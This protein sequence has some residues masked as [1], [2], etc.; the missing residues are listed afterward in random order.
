MRGCLIGEE[1]AADLQIFLPQMVSLRGVVGTSLCRERVLRLSLHRCQCAI[2]L[3]I[4]HVR[5]NGTT[6]SSARQSG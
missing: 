1:V 4:V 6:L 2:G 3:A 5:Q